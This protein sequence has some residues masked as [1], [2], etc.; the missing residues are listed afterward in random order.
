MLQG[1]TMEA[2][3]LI[4]PI[5]SKETTQKAHYSPPWAD[6]SIIGVAGSLSNYL[7]IRTHCP[8]TVVPLTLIEIK[9][10]WFWEDFPCC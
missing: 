7:R 1:T 4:T 10:F 6:M 9:R 3:E 2:M 8:I 5:V